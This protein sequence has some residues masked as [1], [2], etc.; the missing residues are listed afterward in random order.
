MNLIIKDIIDISFH[1][2]FD[3]LLQ[4]VYKVI[5]NFILQSN[6]VLTQGLKVLYV[7]AHLLQDRLESLG[8]WL[9]KLLCT[10]HYLFCC[11]YIKPNLSYLLF[12]FVCFKS[13]RIWQFFTPRLDLILN[14]CNILRHYIRDKLNNI[15]GHNNITNLLYH[16]FSLLLK[17]RNGNYVCLALQIFLEYLIYVLFLIL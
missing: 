4:L 6:V 1:Y 7:L 14:K 10:L 12:S 11:S 17:I 13:N 9:S 5:Q 2:K 16:Q 3:W 8:A 15:V